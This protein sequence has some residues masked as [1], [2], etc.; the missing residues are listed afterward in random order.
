[1]PPPSF[2]SVA[3]ET[4]DR[5]AYITL[6]RPERLNAIDRYMPGEIGDAVELA[7][8]DRDVHVIILQGAGRSFCAGYDLKQFAEVGDGIQ[9]VWSSKRYPPTSSTPGSR[10]LPIAWPGYRSTSS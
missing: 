7:N 5:K 10:S 1:M 6:E 8:D 2:Q 9:G 4:R 3:Y